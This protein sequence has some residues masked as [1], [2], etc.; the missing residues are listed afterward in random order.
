MIWLLARFR[1][2]SRLLV[3]SRIKTGIK[4]GPESLVSSNDYSDGHKGGDHDKRDL[5]HMPPH[6]E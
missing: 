2:G 4:L 3:F 1:M 6:P 5:E